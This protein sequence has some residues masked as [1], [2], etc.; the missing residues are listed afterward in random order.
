LKL[1]S[2]FPCPL[3]SDLEEEREVIRVLE[4]V[5]TFD[6][7]KLH[8]SLINRVIQIFHYWKSSK[9][10][11][12][13][14]HPNLKPIE[15]KSTALTELLKI[16]KLTS[17]YTRPR[18]FAQ[19]VKKVITDAAR[20]KNSESFIVHEAKFRPQVEPLKLALKNLEENGG[21]RGSIAAFTAT[22]SP[23]PA[24]PTPIKKERDSQHFD[25]EIRNSTQA[26]DDTRT[27]QKFQMDKLKLQ[28]HQ[29]LLLISKICLHLN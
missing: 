9:W 23:A 19:E 1:I 10:L 3:S 5:D 26:S 4:T 13:S 17:D 11:T 27:N 7:S 14:I 15:I 12:D 16:A 25:R 18:G 22:A 28:E 6:L 8:S 2:F 24:K 29:H 20:R 21:I